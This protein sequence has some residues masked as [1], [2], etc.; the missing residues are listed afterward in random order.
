MHMTPEPFLNLDACIGRCGT[1]CDMSE[2]IGAYLWRARLHSPPSRLFWDGILHTRL[3]RAIHM[4]CVTERHALRV[5][6][7][8][9]GSEPCLASTVLWTSVV[10]LFPTTTTPYHTP[11]CYP[12]RTPGCPTPDTGS[13]LR[14][15]V[16]TLHPLHTHCYHLPLFLLFHLAWDGYTMFNHRGRH[17]PALNDIDLG[18]TRL[19]VRTRNFLLVVRHPVP[20]ATHHTRRGWTG[21]DA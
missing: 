9:L 14:C 16:L 18:W 1:V 19:L 5:E 20:A 21:G 11:H 15:R 10:V 2:L 4:P 12:P 8:W 3:P 17:D 13:W 6:L 7:S